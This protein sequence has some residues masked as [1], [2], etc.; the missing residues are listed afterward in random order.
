MLTVHDFSPTVI[1]EVLGH[2][3][4]LPADLETEVHA[5]WQAAQERRGKSLF[6]GR[7]LSA[8]EIGSTRIAGYIVEY[9]RLI[10]QRA[11]PDLF[12][13]L[14]VRPVAVSGLLHCADGVVFGRRAGSTTQD[15]GRWELV[16]AGGVDTNGVEGVSRID[17]K[18]QI[19]AELLEEVGLMPAEVAEVMPFCLIEDHDS[20]VIDIGIGL[21]A[22]GLTSDTVLHAHREGGSGEYGELAVVPQMHIADFIERMSPGVVSVSRALLREYEHLD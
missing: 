2:A 21:K 8:S 22:P 5:L 10:A 13:V 7:I 11:R 16:P 12:P 9:R 1:V 15:A 20:H 18:R 19:L 6:N 4:A 3:P 14:R 17:I